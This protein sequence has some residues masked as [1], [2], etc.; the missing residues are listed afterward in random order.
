MSTRKF[1][2]LDWWAV[3]LALTAALAVKFGIVPNIPW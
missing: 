1:I 2:G 3:I